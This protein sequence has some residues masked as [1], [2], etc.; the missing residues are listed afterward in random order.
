MGGESSK[1]LKFPTFLA[2]TRNAPI[3]TT[4]TCISWTFDPGTGKKKKEKKKKEERKSP[5]FRA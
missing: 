4:G 5:R 1:I 2:M 3:G